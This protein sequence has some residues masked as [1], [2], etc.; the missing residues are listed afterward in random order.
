V[1]MESSAV[2]DLKPLH[3]SRSPTPFPGGWRGVFLRTRPAKCRPLNS[4]DARLSSPPIP[5]TSHWVA[6]E[7]C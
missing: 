3:H 1:Q 6:A 4:V 2:T 7:R 5:M